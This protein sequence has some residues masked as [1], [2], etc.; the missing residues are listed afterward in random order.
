LL[1]IALAV[2]AFAF[3]SMDLYCTPPFN[4]LFYCQ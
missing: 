3:D 1:C 4:V 2:G